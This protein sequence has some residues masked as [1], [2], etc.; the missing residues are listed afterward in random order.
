MEQYLDFLRHNTFRRTLLCHAD[1]ELDRIMRPARAHHLYAS[2]RTQ[3]LERDPQKP[4][5]TRFR[6][7][8]NATFATDHPVT[9]VAL[10]HL[11]AE[12]PR[13]VAFSDLVDHTARRF[14]LEQI[15]ADDI[16][17]LA[18]NLL[19]GF[20]YSMQ[21]VE[22]HAHAPAFTRIVSERPLASKLARYQVQFSP[23]VSNLRHERVELDPFGHV[24]LPYLNGKHD[25]ATLLH[26]IRQI[27]ALMQQLADS[28]DPTEALES[29]LTR[30]LNWLARTALLEG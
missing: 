18:I 23:I 28:E 10:E 20:S 1:L 14:G 22:F 11:S 21:L 19:Q 8:D 3:P 2:S 30:T 13:A 17:T 9:A 24:L 15:A 7:S 25:R 6:S 29:E 4:T 5:V 12:S 26:Q 27:D 16:Q